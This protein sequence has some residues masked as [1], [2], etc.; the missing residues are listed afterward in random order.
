MGPFMRGYQLQSGGPQEVEGQE[1]KHFLEF[2]LVRATWSKRDF[3]YLL[4]RLA[5]AVVWT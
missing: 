5:L 2:H 4:A 1:H 3:S